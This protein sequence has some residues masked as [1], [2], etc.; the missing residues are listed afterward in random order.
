MQ[1]DAVLK[2][3][4]DLLDFTVSPQAEAFN[5]IFNNLELEWVAA[6]RLPEFIKNNSP[7]K[8][9]AYRLLHRYIVSKPLHKES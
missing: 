6:M 5:L 2:F 9:H 1:A 7:Y 4:H 8:M 3:L